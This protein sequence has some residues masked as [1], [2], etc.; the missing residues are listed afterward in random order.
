[1]L[2]PIVILNKYNKLKGEVNI[3]NELLSRFNSKILQGRN[4]SVSYQGNVEDI[5]FFFIKGSKTRC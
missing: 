2:D 4:N 5:E 3:I 1:V